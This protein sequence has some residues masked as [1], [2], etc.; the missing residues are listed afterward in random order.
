[1]FKREKLQEVITV[2]KLYLNAHPGSARAAFNLG[3]AYQ[4]TGDYD[5]ALKYLR[6]SMQ[7]LPKDQS[8]SEFSRHFIQTTAPKLMDE[9][10]SP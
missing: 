7:L 8:L 4:E 2:H 1:M 9:I 5:T 6:Q 3:K 10:D